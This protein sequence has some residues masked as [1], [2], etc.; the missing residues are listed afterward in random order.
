MPHATGRAWLVLVPDAEPPDRAAV[1]RALAASLGG[2]V[3]S[4]HAVAVDDSGANAAVLSAV[5]GAMEPV[6]VLLPAARDPILA[7]KKTLAAIA[8]ACAGRECVVLLQGAPS[9]LPLW[10]KFAAANRLEM[11]M[12]PVP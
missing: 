11:E 4:V 2:S 5:Q 3:R 1:E 7:I 6:A 12:M 10:R 9:R 8:A